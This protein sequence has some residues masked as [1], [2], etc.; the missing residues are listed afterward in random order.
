MPTDDYGYDF[1]P[2]DPP[3][4]SGIDARVLR[5]RLREMGRENRELRRALAAAEAAA[6]ETAAQPDSMGAGGEVGQDD[7][8]PAAMS[9]A[10]MAARLAEVEAQCAA[11]AR[12]P[13]GVSP[14]DRRAFEQ[15]QAQAEGALPPTTGLEGLLA[16]WSDRGIPYPQLLQENRMWGFRDPPA[17]G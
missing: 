17:N 2:D 6:A 13:V 14:E 4:R 15:V 10:A 16:R 9:D 3:R 8:P 7:P 5:A 11:L 1:P 12:E